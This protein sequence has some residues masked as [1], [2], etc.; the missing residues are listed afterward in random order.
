MPAYKRVLLKISGEAL[1]GQ[2]AFGIEP[3]TL[4]SIARQI[5]AVNATGIEMAIVVGGGNIWRGASASASGMERA[6]ADYAG[7]LATVINALALQDA[8]EN[9]G[10]WVRTQSAITVQ[11]IAEPYIRRRAMRHLEK[12]R[13]VIFAA[14]T[15][16]PYMTTDTAAAL[17]AIEIGADVLLMA[18]NSVDGVY[19]SDPRTNPAARRFERLPYIEALNRRLEVMDSTALSLCM[20]NHLPIVVFDVTSP[21][22]IIRVA[23]GEQRGTLVGDHEVVLEEL[24]PAATSGKPGA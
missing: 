22:S 24:S 11:Q 19:D 15:G 17:R 5:K 18:K 7:M 8:L 1:M 13:V 10:V 6:T 4:N 12:G 3:T 16:N 14:G 21:D 20:E 2:A 23:H 9:A